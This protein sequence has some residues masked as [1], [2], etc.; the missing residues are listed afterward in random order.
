MKN[1]IV[2][3]LIAILITYSCGILAS[4]WFDF[5]IH[6][7]QHILGPMESVVSVTAVGAVMA[8]VGVIVAI[9]VFGAL[10]LAL[11]VVLI[12]MLFAGVTVF[13]PMLLVIAF[14]FWLLK[15]KRQTQY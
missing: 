12:A 11:F 7:D 15:D 1:F 5:S 14:I 13:W 2:A 9:S 4:E 10:A 8:I 6:F 3:V